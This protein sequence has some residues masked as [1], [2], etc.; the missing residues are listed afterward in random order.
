MVLPH[1]RPFGDGKVVVYVELAKGSKIVAFPIFNALPEFPDD[2]RL[3]LGVED[4]VDVVGDPNTS[5]Q[6]VLQLA[7]ITVLVLCSLF[8]DGLF[9]ELENVLGSVEVHTSSNNLYFVTLCIG[10]IKNAESSVSGFRQGFSPSGNSSPR[11]DNS[12]FH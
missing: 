6:P 12:Q 4:V 10:L 9:I 7:S 1:I 2:S 8:Q 5:C 3:F 11:W